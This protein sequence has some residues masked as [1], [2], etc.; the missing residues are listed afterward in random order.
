MKREFLGTGWKFPLTLDENND[1][2]LVSEEEKISEA[3][4]IILSTV[5][6]ERVMRPEFGCGIHK[7]NPFVRM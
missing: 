3:I 4:V 1:F 7:T 2:E 5:P 6:G